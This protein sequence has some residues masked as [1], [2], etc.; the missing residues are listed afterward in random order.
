MAQ[1]I[2]N[3]AADLDPASPAA[4]DAKAK[5]K[6]DRRKALDNLFDALVKKLGDLD[7]TDAE[8]RHRLVDADLI[9]SADNIQADRLDPERAEEIA[10]AIVSAGNPAVMFVMLS[11]LKK[12]ARDLL[13][14][15]DASAQPSRKPTAHLNATDK[16]SANPIVPP[17][18]RI[19]RRFRKRA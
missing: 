3:A 17:R 11:T 7:A 12:G 13:K 4:R 14:S 10:D 5:S 19:P 1:Q 9:D 18:N 15:D 6:S 8:I 2:V 16:Q